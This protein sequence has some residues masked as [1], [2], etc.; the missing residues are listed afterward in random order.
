M[1]CY[2]ANFPSHPFAQQP[3]PKPVVSEMLHYYLQ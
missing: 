2:K 1:P 3:K